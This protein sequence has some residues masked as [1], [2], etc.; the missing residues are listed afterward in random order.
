MKFS[1][2]GEHALCALIDLG[3][4][5]ELGWPM[6]PISDKRAGPKEKLTINSLS[7]T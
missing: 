4:V 3:I 2:R 7:T 5:S 6:L 1:K